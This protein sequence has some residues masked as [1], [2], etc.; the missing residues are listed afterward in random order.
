MKRSPTRGIV[1]LITSLVLLGALSSSAVAA[2]GGNSANA[3]LCQ[4]AG[5]TDLQR[6]DGTTFT[7]QGA[8]VSYAAQ[9][10]TLEPQSPDPVTVSFLLGSLGDI[11]VCGIR[12]DVV[13][14]APDTYEVLISSEQE[15][16]YPTLIRV[17]ADGTGSVQTIPPDRIGGTL[18]S[19]GDTVTATVAG[20]T[21]DPTVVVC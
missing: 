12:V 21:S 17:G 5:W 7:N 11:G 3:K 13:G 15:A 8:C 14:F 2:P 18:W 10:G 1:V 20:V 6:S 4:K 19:E 16:D 9:G